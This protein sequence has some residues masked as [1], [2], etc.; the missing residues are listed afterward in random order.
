MPTVLPIPGTPGQPRKRSR[1]TSLLPNLDVGGR[2]V[3]TL[4]ADLLQYVESKGN[5]LIPLTIPVAPG[6]ATRSGESGR[7]RWAIGSITSVGLALLAICWIDLQTRGN[8]NLAKNDT[9]NNFVN[10]PPP[11]APVATVEGLTIFAVFIA[12]A[13]AVERLLEPLSLAKTS[14][15]GKEVEVA[16]ATD[17][18]VS[19]LAEVNSARS[20]WI[21]KVQAFKEDKPR[22]LEKDV[23]EAGGIADAKAKEANDAGDKAAVKVDELSDI[24]VARTV[25]YWALATIVGMTA[26]AVLEMYFLRTVGISNGPLWIEILATGLIISGGSKPLHEAIGR[27][28]KPEPKD[29][30][31]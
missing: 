12:A 2:S 6:T 16:T 14:K 8:D 7:W 26:A 4:D 5:Q 17:L 29:T 22:V 15:E 23:N 25:T 1:R 19:K 21:E 20:A 10:A 24:N 28:Q 30:A 3:R 11:D 31:T 18:W 27:L 9:W 13:L